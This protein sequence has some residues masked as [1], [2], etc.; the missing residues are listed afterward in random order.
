MTC[1]FIDFSWDFL[2]LSNTSSFR[3]SARF[4]ENTIDQEP[5]CDVSAK[6]VRNCAP[7]PIDITIED[8]IVHPH[9]KQ[10]LANDIALLRLSSSVPMD[11]KD[12][13]NTVCLPTTQDLQK[14][15]D[16]FLVAG[17]G[18]TVNSSMSK[19]LLKATVSRQF[20]ESCR[21]VFRTEI[22]PDELIICAG[23]ENLV[24]TCAGDSGGPLF[25]KARIHS[26][27]R[28]IQY[29]LT[30]NG[31]YRCGQKL[32]GRTPPSM[33]TNIAAHIDWIRSSMY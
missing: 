33:Y 23:G 16:T 4:G 18:R 22:I 10:L 25:W 5:D 9:F 29:G 24:D 20:I 32:Q 12:Y 31:Y 1:K 15:E 11:N 19:H 3:E 28:Y 30:G 6:G 21:T 26:A 14:R 8:K 13:V 27:S 17:W 2:S 7:T